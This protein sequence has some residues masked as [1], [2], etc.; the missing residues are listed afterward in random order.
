MMLSLGLAWPWVHL[1]TL[2]LQLQPLALYGDGD[3]NTLR[4]SLQTPGEH[5]ASGDELADML[6]LE[7]GW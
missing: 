5:S 2:R 6:G 1:R 4:T 3:F 7:A